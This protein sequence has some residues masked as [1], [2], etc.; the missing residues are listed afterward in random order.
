ML[1]RY[2]STT[3][4]QSW[5]ARVCRSPRARRRWSSRQSRRAERGI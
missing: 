3:S 5:T 1:G 4:R 2:G